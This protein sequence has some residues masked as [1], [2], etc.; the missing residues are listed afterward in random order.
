MT[1][2]VSYHFHGE[3]TGSV[4]RRDMMRRRLLGQIAHEGQMGH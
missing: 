1:G 4:R 3:I 2:A